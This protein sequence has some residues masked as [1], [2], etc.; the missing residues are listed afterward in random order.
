[1]QKSKRTTT[2]NWA[3]PRLTERQMLY[4]ADDAQVALRIYRLALAAG[5]LPHA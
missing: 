2:S 5:H 1:M 4:A 3:N